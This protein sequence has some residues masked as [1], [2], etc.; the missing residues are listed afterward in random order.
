MKVKDYFVSDLIDQIV[1]ERAMAAKAVTMV[2]LAREYI[3]NETKNSASN[4]IDS[5]TL[6]YILGMPEAEREQK[7]YDDFM[8][9]DPDSFQHDYKDELEKA[10]YIEETEEEADE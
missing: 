5:N 2:R 3:N 7:R 9:A 6:R 10:A 8:D 4:Y 1:A